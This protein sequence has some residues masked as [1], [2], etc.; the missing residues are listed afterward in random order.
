MFAG[1]PALERWWAAVQGDKDMARII[2]EMRN[3][4]SDWESS[5]RWDQ[6]GISAQVRVVLGEN[7]L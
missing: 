7:I 4:L 2:T 5:H 3:G 1:R 6:L